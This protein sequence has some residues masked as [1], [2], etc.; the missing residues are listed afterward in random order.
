M[1]HIEYKG[2][3]ICPSK[4]VCV[5]RNYVEHIEE[6]NN[7]IPSEL[8]VFIKPNSAISND[9]VCNK[10]DQIHYECEIC[11]LIYGNAIAGIGIGLDLTK[12]A[13][14]TELKNKG[15]PWERAKSFD[16][17]AV[18]SEFVSAPEDLTGVTMELHIN[19]ELIQFAT[20][21]LMLN[22]PSQVLEELLSFLSIENGDVVMS[23]TP[24]GVGVV[25]EGDVFT[26][27]LFNHGRVLVEKTWAV[28]V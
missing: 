27:K 4:I 16:K 23:G 2:R 24:K 17:S 26:G 28:A 14:Q 3:N 5:G 12:R 15:L 10:I 8:V 18:F 7:E 19:G 13:I 1:N 21:D 11:F 9:L 22:K 6:L 25:N 20:Y